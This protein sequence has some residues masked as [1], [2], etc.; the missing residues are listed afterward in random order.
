MDKSRVIFF[1]RGVHCGGTMGE[2]AIRLAILNMLS[3]GLLIFFKGK[4]LL[5]LSRSQMKDQEEGDFRRENANMIIWRISK[6]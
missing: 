3:L 1:S 4:D 6:G 5:R 2:P